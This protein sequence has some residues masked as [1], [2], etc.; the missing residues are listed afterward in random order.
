[1][2]PDIKDA[3]I[4]LCGHQVYSG[5]QIN[6]FVL[7]KIIFHDA[8]IR[9][10]LLNIISNNVKTEYEDFHINSKAPYTIFESGIIFERNISDRF[11]RIIG[12]IADK[13]KRIERVK[14]RSGLTEKQIE[15]I[16]N[17]QFSE[18]KTI[19]HSDFIVNTNDESTTESQCLTIHNQL[20][21]GNNN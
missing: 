13:T 16:I 11:D 21:N 9:N 2:K 3:I 5:G 15:S 6:K 17:T 1:M 14:N 12:V 10:K 8:D 18:I 20:I 7:S 4:A 19:E